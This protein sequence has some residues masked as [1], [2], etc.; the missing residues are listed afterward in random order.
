MIGVALPAGDDGDEMRFPVQ[1]LCTN[2]TAGGDFLLFFLFLMSLL[3]LHNFTNLFVL[4][5]VV[6]VIDDKE[7]VIE[8]LDLVQLCET[9]M[10]RLSL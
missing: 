6:G 1:Q 3:M 10:I 7:D 9:Q 5:V 2:L 4:D 8:K